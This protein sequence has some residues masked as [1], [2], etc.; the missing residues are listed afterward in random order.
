MLG[1]YSRRGTFVDITIRHAE[2]DDAEAIHR[3][4]GGPRA[5]QGTLQLPLQAAESWRKWLSETPEGAHVEPP[6]V[7]RR[8]PALE[9]V[10]YEA[11]ASRASRQGA[12]PLIEGD[13]TNS[14]RDGLTNGRERN[15]TETNPFDADTDN[16]K[17]RDGNEDEDDEAASSDECAAGVEDDADEDMDGDDLDDDDENDFGERQGDDD[18][19]NDGTEDGLEDEDEDGEQDGDEDD[20]EKDEDDDDDDDDGVPDEDDDDADDDDYAS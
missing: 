7:R 1:P 4:M 3:I 10:L 9:P 19:D 2:P 15:V 6:G 8:H 20:G 18:T 5:V 11:R 13:L 14:D 16:D 12:R 17:I